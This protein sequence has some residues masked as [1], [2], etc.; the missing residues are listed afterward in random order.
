MAFE[1]SGVVANKAGNCFL[2]RAPYGAGTTI[3]FTKTQT[4]KSAPICAKCYGLEAAEPHKV[5]GTGNDDLR[6]RVGNL[7]E[8][9]LENSRH[10]KKIAWLE[11][12]VAELLV[13][14]TRGKERWKE[15]GCRLAELEADTEE[16]KDRALTP[17]EI[18][19]KN[20]GDIDNIFGG[21]FKSKYKE[22]K[23]AEEA[24]LEEARAVLPQS[25]LVAVGGPELPEDEMPF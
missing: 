21:P 9:A 7:E 15:V 22:A 8:L 6:K 12:K 24:A 16:L 3:Y 23:L 4:D 10:I 14:A 19:Q 13:I 2:C 1:Q 5:S 11:E 25:K 17:A 20:S 18:K